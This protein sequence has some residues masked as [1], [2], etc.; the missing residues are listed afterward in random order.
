M[1]F[2]VYNPPREFVCIIIPKNADKI[3]IFPKN[4]FNYFFFYDIIDLEKMQGKGCCHGD[5]G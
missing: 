2:M 4:F 1:D 3:K 5:D